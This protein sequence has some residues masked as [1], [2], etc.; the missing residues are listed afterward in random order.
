MSI[1]TPQDLL[2]AIE[3]AFIGDCKC[4]FVAAIY[5]YYTF[6]NQFVDDKFMQKKEEFTNLGWRYQKMTEEEE[7]A[8]PALLDVAV[9][10]KKV[11]QD[12]SV[13]L[14]EQNPLYDGATNSKAEIFYPVILATK[15]MPSEATYDEERAVGISILVE[16]P[17]GT[18]KPH[19]LKPWAAQYRDFMK[20]MSKKFPRESEKFIFAAWDAFLKAEMPLVPNVNPPQPSDNVFDFVVAKGSDF[21]PP[22]SKYLYGSSPLGFMGL[23]EGRP[24][25]NTPCAPSTLDTAFTGT[26][27]GKEVRRLLRFLF[28]FLTRP[29]CPLSHSHL[30]DLD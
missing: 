10:Y 20:G 21:Q 15:W 6:Y 22:L 5:D 18:P 11:A 30:A 26:F 25:T 29:H 3:D 14:R 24:M 1:Y 2:K 13:E 27:A 23:R 4:T 19:E 8:N 17:H 7:R 16:Q 9:N 28:S 12:V